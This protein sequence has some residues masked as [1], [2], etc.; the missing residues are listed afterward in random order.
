[1]IAMFYLSSMCGL[2]SWVIGCRFWYIYYNVFK[3]SSNWLLC[4]FFFGYVWGE[5][6]CV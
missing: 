3:W 1:M 6:D 5:V 2:D 4:F